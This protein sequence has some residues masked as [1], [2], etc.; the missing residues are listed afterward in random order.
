MSLDKDKA[1]KNSQMKKDERDT[2]GRLP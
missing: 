2:D 1:D